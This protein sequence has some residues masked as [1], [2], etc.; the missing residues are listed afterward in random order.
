MHTLIQKTSRLGLFVVVGSLAGCGLFGGQDGLFRDRQNDYKYSQP[1]QVMVVPEHTEMSKLRPLLPIEG[2]DIK[3]VPGDMISSG[4]PFNSTTVG[5]AVAKPKLTDSVTRT[6]NSP[7]HSQT[8]SESISRTWHL[9]QLSLQKAGFT[10]LERSPEQSKSVVTKLNED[11]EQTEL[12]VITLDA[13]SEV[14]TRLDFM[15]V[16]GQ[17][18][19]DVW[20][21]SLM[22]VLV[23]HSS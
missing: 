15:S 16:H 13:I 18:V 8:V 6:Q 12:M 9:L 11:G 14:E 5:V 10:V 17:N 4:N 22:D 2:V 20:V 7:F 3:P 19:S 21:T 1:G 23:Q